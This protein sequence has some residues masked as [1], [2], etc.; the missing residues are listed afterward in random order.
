MYDDANDSLHAWI[1]KFIDTRSPKSTFVHLAFQNG[2]VSPVL[3][4]ELR[5]QG[6]IKT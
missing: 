6:P 4:L 2:T 3:P 5:K 1:L